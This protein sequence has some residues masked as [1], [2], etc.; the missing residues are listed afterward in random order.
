[1][2]FVYQDGS[3]AL[4]LAAMANNPELVDLLDVDDYT[5]SIKDKASFTYTI[6]ILTLA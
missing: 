4:H 1:M 2:V 6:L 5:S 3:T